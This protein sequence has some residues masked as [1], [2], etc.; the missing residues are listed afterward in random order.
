[1]TSTR[2]RRSGVIPPPSAPPPRVDSRSTEPGTLFVPALSPAG[3]LPSA[4]A[5]PSVPNLPTDQ[6]EVTS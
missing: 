6:P 3:V 5:P 1:M 4:P 2:N